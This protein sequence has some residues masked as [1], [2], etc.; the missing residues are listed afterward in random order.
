MRNSKNIIDFVDKYEDRLEGFIDGEE[1]LSVAEKYKKWIDDLEQNAYQTC[2]VTDGNFSTLEISVATPKMSTTL[3]KLEV[4]SG[5][6]ILLSL[7]C[8]AKGP[9]RTNEINVEI[10]ETQISYKVL[11]ND[12]N[13]FEA[14]CRVKSDES[15]HE[16]YLEVDKAKEQYS[17]AYESRTQKRDYSYNAYLNDSMEYTAIQQYTFKGN[18]STNGDTTTITVDRII[19]GYSEERKNYH[20]E[21]NYERAIELD[22]TLMIDRKDKMPSHE[23]AYNTLSNITQEDVDGWIGKIWSMIIGQIL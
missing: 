19:D 16:I 1:N 21:N 18:W 15:A 20:G 8:G 22:C 2:G 10:K 6:D 3:L 12:R 9:R 14:V 13:S 23:K 4:K 11:K 5:D 7:D 17:L